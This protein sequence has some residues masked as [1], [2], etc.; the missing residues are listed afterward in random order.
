MLVLLAT[1]F[2]TVA[3][4]TRQFTRDGI[5]YVLGPP[6]RAWS[7]VSLVDVHDHFEFI[8]LYPGELNP[9]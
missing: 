8:S 3:G 4:Q 6:S 7:E 9:K 1:S 5:E 2:V